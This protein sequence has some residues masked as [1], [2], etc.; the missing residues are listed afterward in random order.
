[1]DFSADF[2]ATVLLGLV[3][4]FV[5]EKELKFD[6]RQMK[7][8]NSKEANSFLKSRYSYKTE[9]LPEKI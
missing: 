6:G 8:T 9:F 7:F 1:V 3:P 5:P 4:N 2:A